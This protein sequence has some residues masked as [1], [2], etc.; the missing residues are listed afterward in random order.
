MFLYATP[1]DLAMPLGGDRHFKVSSVITTCG[2]LGQCCCRRD[3]WLGFQVAVRTWLEE[4]SSVTRFAISCLTILGL[5]S[6]ASGSLSAQT[7][8]VL[9]ERIQTTGTVETISPGVV[10]ITDAD[11]KR[12][13]YKIQEKDQPGISLA[14]AEALIRFPAKVKITGMLSTDALTRGTLVRFAGK[15]NRLGRTEGTL[16]ELVLFDEGAETLGIE[17]AQQ[18]ASPGEYSDCTI[19][20][21]V[22]SFRD[23]H[24]VVTVPPGEFVRNQRL[25][26]RVDEKATIRLE[27]DDYRRGR[28]GDRVVRLVAARFST[29]DV[30][31]QELDIE[32]AAQ[33]VTG[34]ASVG[35]VA[36]QYRQ[37]S[38]EPRGPRDVRS[39]HFLLH[40]DVS[41][42]DARMLLDKLETMIGLVSQYY[43]RLPNGLIECYVVRDLNSWPPGTFSP[44]AVAKINEPAGVTLSVTLGNQT[45]AV[46]YSCDEHG[47][48]QHEAVHAY[49]S[50]TF[51]S[52]GPTWYAEG[53]AEMGNYWKKD[54]PAVDL[55]PIAIDYL[56]KAEPKKLLDI[57][58][59]G[60]FT[61]DS[62]R[63]YA[64]RWALCYLLANNPNYSVRFKALGIAMMS[65][66]PGATF[67]SVYGPVAREVSF[68][69]DFFVQ[70]LDN[71]YRADL[72]A[73]QWN[74][75][76]QYIPG[77]RYATVNVQARY[78]WQ[79][80]GVKLQAGQS[81]DYAAKGTWKL[82]ADGDEVEADGRQ[83]GRGRLAG[84]LM[85]D[86]RLGEPIEMG[87]RG[88][89]IAA[90]DGDLYLRCRDDWNR[91]ADN[92]GQITVYLRKT[93]ES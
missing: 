33:S 54:Q 79:A 39:A 30:A 52:T 14:G 44:E 57:V 83:D 64:W 81:Y 6:V 86:Y 10:E 78:G 34:S 80:S 74:R 1:A 55:D 66:T 43:G 13:E 19:R 67:E 4:T 25:A 31:I 18:A 46:V 27:S 2:W 26:F 56:K 65:E 28:R 50:Q 72:C 77:S 58:A 5:L 87:V 91:I 21:E 75:K 42:R 23:N 88:T 20:G 93:P 11:G 48:V 84:I 62:W 22:Y 36:S 61:G 76:F 8:I 38:D 32:I 29:G 17:V 53:M 12:Q 24:L 7:T 3:K 89:F 35:D 49:C 37:L 40:T 85:N 73:W 59:A 41:D 47:V 63:N 68:E 60:Q 92:D 15:V 70:T 45:R 71:G 51:G 9:Q 82:E 69:Y 90:Q 16:S